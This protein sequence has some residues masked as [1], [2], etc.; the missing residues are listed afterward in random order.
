MTEFT[1][2]EVTKH[3]AKYITQEFTKY[4]TLLAVQIWTAKCDLNKE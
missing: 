2:K 4:S 3:Y 1:V